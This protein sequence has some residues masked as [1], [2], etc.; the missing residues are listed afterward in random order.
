MAANRVEGKLEELEGRPED[1]DELAAASSAGL[2][3]HVAG[4][5]AQF[6]N[7]VYQPYSGEMTRY[8]YG[9]DLSELVQHGV[10]KPAYHD[11]ILMGN[12]RTVSGTRTRRSCETGDRQT[13]RFPRHSHL[14]GNSGMRS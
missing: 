11:F 4:M 2:N 10:L 1:L 12:F 9:Q 5:L 8:T 13:Q 6:A 3:R 7:A 14:T